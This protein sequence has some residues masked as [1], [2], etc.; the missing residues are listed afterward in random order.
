MSK[1]VKTQYSVLVSPGFV[2]NSEDAD[3]EVARFD[4]LFRTYYRVIRRAAR[5][6]ISDRAEADDL[7]AEVFYAAWRRRRDA[8][9]V[10]TLA[11]LYT[12]LRHRVGV[13]Y[14]RRRRAENRL[15]AVEDWL[16]T[17]AAAASDNELVR[18][19]MWLL[20]E[21][22]RTLLSMWFWEGMSGAEMAEVLGCTVEAVHVRIHRS[23]RRLAE[24]LP[25]VEQ[26]E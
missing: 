6:R 5:T 26:A 15:R 1:K 23:K 19:T 7:A 25:R 3:D 22:E 12:T 13:E 16:R 24:K 10:F 17:D 21:R 2:D 11:W 20:P 14:R 4:E 18:E 9:R 8:D